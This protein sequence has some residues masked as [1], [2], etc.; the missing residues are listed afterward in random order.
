MRVLHINLSKGWRGGERQ[1]LLLMQGLR[2]RGVECVLVAPAAEPLS[3]RARADGFEVVPSAGFRWL[4]ARA[5]I[6]HAHEARGLQLAFFRKLLHRCPVVTTR[7][8]IFRPTS[9]LSTRLKYG[10]ADR[11][12]AISQGVAQV[13]TEWGARPERIRVIY[14]AVSTEDQSRP[15][16]VGNLRV[17]FAGKR[18]VG[19]IGAFTPEKDHATLLRAA[20]RVQQEQPGVAFVLLGDGELRADLEKQATA[21]GLKDVFFEGFQDD[22]YSYLRTFEAF[23][24]TS[25]AEGLGSSILDAFTYG[26]P[27]VATLAGGVAELVCDGA[28]GVPCAVGDD[29]AIAQGILS[30]LRDSALAERLRTGA[31][32]RLLEEFTADRMTSRYVEVYTELL[33]QKGPRR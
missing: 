3:D 14:S 22:P 5:D 13:M 28:S 8:V 23:V 2:T 26:V 24:L 32:R 17:R 29:A 21:L 25:R 18:I 6:T 11:I 31:R 16:R 1:T 19:C 20:R 4:R 7:R 15:D 9:R 33:D 27:V 10:A 30:V 12:F